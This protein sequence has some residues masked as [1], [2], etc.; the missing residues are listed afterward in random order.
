MFLK[1]IEINVRKTQNQIYACVSY[2]G[3]LLYDMS[4][5]KIA[6]IKYTQFCVIT[7]ISSNVADWRNLTKKV[8]ES[9]NW[10]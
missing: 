9:T 5:C 8:K 7:I 10:Q 6:K 4:Q 2:N 3:I 1:S